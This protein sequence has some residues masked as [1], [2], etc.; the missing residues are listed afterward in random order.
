[1]EPNSSLQLLTYVSITME[2]Q[3]QTFML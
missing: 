1:V 2:E 3:F